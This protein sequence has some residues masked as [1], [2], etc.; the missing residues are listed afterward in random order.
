MDKVQN[1]SGLSLEDANGAVKDGVDIAV[2]RSRV[3]VRAQAVADMRAQWNALCAVEGDERARRAY[4]A[5]AKTPT[6]GSGRLTALSRPAA[7]LIWTS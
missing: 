1:D 3:R 5:M 4:E 2:G 6:G 7:R